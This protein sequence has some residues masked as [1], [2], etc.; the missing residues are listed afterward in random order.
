M[1]SLNFHIQLDEEVAKFFDAEIKLCT[2][3]CIISEADALKKILP[4]PLQILQRCHISKCQH[5]NKPVSATE[6][7]LSMVKENNCRHYVVATQDKNL[8]KSLH[9]IP[10]VPILFI[11]RTLCLESPSEASRMVELYGTTALEPG[12]T[13]DYEQ[14]MLRHLKK[15]L[16]GKK[17]K[18]EIRKR[19]KPKGPNPLS[20]KKKKTEKNPVP[21]NQNGV[22]KMRKKR[23]QIKMSA[24]V[25]EHMNKS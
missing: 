14:V 11:D 17:P 12:Q 15:K 25:K 16:L 1:A 6:C 21:Q 24:H 18:V 3:S 8:Q 4:K 23:K 19:K 22:K 9:E 13:V 2:T 10:G 7:L 5:K 20:C